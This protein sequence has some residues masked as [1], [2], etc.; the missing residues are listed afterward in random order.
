MQLKIVSMN[1]AECRPSAEAPSSWNQDRV[2][3]AVRQELLQNNP[4]I[5]ALQECPSIDWLERA[6]TGYQLMGVQ[7]AH[8]GLVALLVRKSWEAQPWS[9]W[10]PLPVVMTKIHLE[11]NKDILIA[12][13][14]LAPFGAADRER[15]IQ[16]EGLLGDRDVKNATLII[17]GD[18]NMRAEEDTVME[19]IYGLVDVWKEAGSNPFTQF[20]WDTRDHRPKLDIFSTFFGCFSGSPQDE[21]GYFNRYYGG[22]TKEYAQRYDRIYIKSTSA[23]IKQVAVESFRLVANKPA[24]KGSRTHFL[25]DHFG[26]VCVLNVQ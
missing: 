19:E 12:S 18:T 5:L 10:R 15:A 16:I 21:Q 3:Q 26:V 23:S 6:F 1:L 24:S 4:D 11:N 8:S 13:C 17:A 7:Q 20:T 25:S 14:H 22:N 9:P 2:A